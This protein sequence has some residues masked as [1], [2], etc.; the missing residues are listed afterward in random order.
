MLDQSGSAAVV[1]VLE[2]WCGPV[3][4]R[5]SLQFDDAERVTS[6]SVDLSPSCSSPNSPPTARV[7][8]LSRADVAAPGK[9]GG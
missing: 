7:T 9:A 3:N 8:G 2:N 4:P 6:E 1:L 5:V